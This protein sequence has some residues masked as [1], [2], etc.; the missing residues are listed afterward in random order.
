MHERLASPLSTLFSSRASGLFT[1]H[2][3]T[4][5]LADVI[6]L[7]HG[8]PGE[9]LRAAA[10][11]RP[12]D[13]NLVH[14]VSLAKPEGQRQFTLAQIAASAGHLL[15]LDLAAR[16]QRDRR[17]GRAAVGVPAITFEREPNPVVSGAALIVQQASGTAILRQHHIEVAIAVD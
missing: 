9:H 12:A 10:L 13:G 6:P 17:S 8:Q 15:I 7:V 16:F 3:L 11:A 5:A 1:L 4:S 14:P 2:R